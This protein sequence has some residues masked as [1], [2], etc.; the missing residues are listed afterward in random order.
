MIDFNKYIEL[1]RSIRKDVL[2]L[3]YEKKAA[4]IGTSFS[5]ADIFAVLYGGFVNL[6]ITNSGSEHD[7]VVILSKGHGA[8]AWYSTLANVGVLDKEKM[9][10]EF[11]TSGFKLGVHPVRNCVNGIKTS[12]GS[13]GQGLGIGCGCALAY[14]INKKRNRVYV[15]L[16]DGECNE[17]SV[18]EAF[19][20]AK[21]YELDNIVAIIDRN[22]L[23]SYG[24]DEDVLN[25]GDMTQK[26]KS[27]GWN[28]I[29]VDGH[30]HEELHKAFE[31]AKNTHKVPTAV[32]ANTIKGKGVSLFED[33]VV[34]HYKWPEK[35]HYELGLR[36]LNKNA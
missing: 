11:N 16:G 21:R 30:N 24:H 5:C 34:W 20:F 35:E 12:T 25:L 4:F 2:K 33:K 3:T 23:Q 9:F 26:I 19:M 27:F 28:A 1:S 13:L 31:L 17:G 22:R 7:D 32:I 29:E 10:E 6:D 15:I 14:K 18:W 36:E 8:S